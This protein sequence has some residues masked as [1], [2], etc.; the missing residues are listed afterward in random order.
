MRLLV[1]IGMSIFLAGC[2]TAYDVQDLGGGRYGVS[3]LACPACGGTAQSAKLA[4][5]QATEFCAIKGQIVMT[6]SQNNAMA[7]AVGAGRTDMI[8]ACVEQVTE[9]D[10]SDCYAEAFAELSTTHDEFVLDK[11]VAIVVPP[12]EGFPFVVLASQDYATEA[13]IAA[14][15]DVGGVWESCSRDSWTNVSTQYRKTYIATSNEIL[16]SLA[17]LVATKTTYGEYAAEVNASLASLDQQL[18]G[19]E[20]EA[21]AQRAA[22]ERQR[23]EAIS[24]YLKK[25]SPNL[26]APAPP[27]PSG[28]TTCTYGGG[29]MIC[30]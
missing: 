14:L 6:E 29:V 18:S 15:R 8:F 28:P 30:N 9:E 25:G 21:R 11:A 20:R 10:T 22:E 5:E 16:V 27:P 2:Q 12:E 19:I 24:D 1:L 26:I 7:N 4:Y 13:E 3:S 23:I 17:K